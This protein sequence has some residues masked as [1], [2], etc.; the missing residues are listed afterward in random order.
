MDSSKFQSPEHETKHL[1]Q[2]K[3]QNAK[4]VITPYIAFVL[5]IPF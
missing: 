5:C 4:R 1:K 3:P 2:H